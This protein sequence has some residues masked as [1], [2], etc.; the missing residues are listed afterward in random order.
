MDRRADLMIQY[1]L[2]QRELEV[3][4]LAE[5]AD[6]AIDDVVMTIE[7][8]QDLVNEREFDKLE[9]L[10]KALGEVQKGI[11]EYA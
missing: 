11:E 8:M 5:E 6:Y 9:K 1:A 10:K 2:V 4:R 7:K 3:R